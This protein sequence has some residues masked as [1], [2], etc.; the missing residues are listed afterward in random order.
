MPQWKKLPNGQWVVVPSVSTYFDRLNKGR[1]QSFNLPD[2]DSENFLLKQA[3]RLR[4]LTPGQR[5]FSAK[6]RKTI[7]GSIREALKAIPG[8]VADL[9]LS[10]AEATIG[11]LTPFAD[12][13]IEKRLRKISQDR[14][15]KR[16]PLYRD[17]L[18]VGV[19]QGLGQVTGLTA[20]TRIPGVGKALGFA[21][22]I[23]L[24]ISDQTRRIAEYEERTGENIPWYKET[25]AHL[26]GGAVGLSEIILPYKLAK[27]GSANRIQKMLSRTVPIDPGTTSGMIRSA[28]ESTATEGIQ[29]GLAQGLQ[30]MTAKGL[31]DP[32]AL[33]DLG[34]SMMEDLKVGGIVGGI[35]DV[36]A[37]ML[38]GPH[39]R[40]RGPQSTE[41]LQSERNEALLR[42]HRWQDEEWGS[43]TLDAINPGFVKDKLSGIMKEYNISRQVAEDINE[44]FNGEFAALPL[45]FETPLLESG[46]E[47]EQ[48][49]SIRDEL[50]T[51]TNSAI[52]V[53][54][55]VGSRA[56]ND[57]SRKDYIN[58][59]DAIRRIQGTRLSTLNTSI[60]KLG[61]GWRNLGGISDT[62]EYLRYWDS[63]GSDA[64]DNPDYDAL[65]A[66]L[67]KVV[68]GA[69]VKPDVVRNAIQGFLGGAYGRKGYKRLAELLG[70]HN[71]PGSEKVLSNIPVDGGLI[72]DPTKGSSDA[73]NFSTDDLGRILFGI[74]GNEG[75][76]KG[77]EYSDTTTLTGDVTKYN[78]KMKELEIELDEIEKDFPLFRVQA[79]QTEVQDDE[80]K[81]RPLLDKK[82]SQQEW[83][84]VRDN[85]SRVL[86]T[87]RGE[88]Y[89][90]MSKIREARGDR[91]TQA[92][93]ERL[94]YLQR[95]FSESGNREKKLQAIERLRFNEQYGKE[96]AEAAFDEWLQDQTVI[97]NDAK[98]RSDAHKAEMDKQVQQ[99]QQDLAGLDP[100]QLVEA[101][102]KMLPALRRSFKRNTKNIS[103]TNL[104]RLS[105]LFAPTSLEATDAV[106]VPM[107]IR[108]MTDIAQ[109]QVRH[110]RKA[111]ES[112]NL[113]IDETV[114][115]VEAFVKE[116]GTLKKRQNAQAKMAKR[117]MQMAGKDAEWKK[118][119]EKNGVMSVNEA[120]LRSKI[121]M[122]DAI[123]LAESLGYNLE[124]MTRLITSRDIEQLLGSKNIFL[125][126]TLAP[127][128]QGEEAVGYIGSR[129]EKKTGRGVDS[130]PF[131][132]LLADMTG[133]T[134]WNNA[135][136]A[137]RLL[138]YSRLLQLPSHR[139]KSSDTESKGLIFQPLY[140][141]DFY[142][143]EQS[144]KHLN[145]I[146][147]EIVGDRQGFQGK[148]DKIREHIKN[149]MGEE[150]D[151]Q[152]FDESIAS[153]IESGLLTH[154]SPTYQQESLVTGQSS[155]D[156]GSVID[157]DKGTPG[158]PRKRNIDKIQES[159][160]GTKDTA[161]DKPL[162]A[163]DT[164]E[165]KLQKIREGKQKALSLGSEDN[166]VNTGEVI[167]VSQNARVPVTVENIQEE[168]DKYAPERGLLIFGRGS[169]GTNEETIKELGVEAYGQYETGFLDDY[170]SLETEKFNPLTG[171]AGGV[172]IEDDVIGSVNMK[173]VEHAYNAQRIDS[174][175]DKGGVVWYNPNSATLKGE[176]D[177]KELI[178]DIIRVTP[179]NRI[180][181]EGNVT[182]LRNESI[183]AL[184]RAMTDAGWV[185]GEYHPDNALRRAMY[186]IAALADTPRAKGRIPV[187]TFINNPML[188][189]K[190][191]NLLGNKLKL[192]ETRVVKRYTPK[193]WKTV[194]IE[195]ETPLKEKDTKDPLIV[196]V[197][198]KKFKE[199]V[200]AK[201]KKKLKSRPIFTRVPEH[202]GLTAKGEERTSNV[203]Y[204]EVGP[205][206][207]SLEDSE[208][209]DYNKLLE[210]KF[211][212][213][214][215]LTKQLMYFP[216]KLEKKKKEDEGRGSG[217]I[218]ERIR[219]K[220]N[221]EMYPQKVKQAQ[222]SPEINSFIMTPRGLISRLHATPKEIK[223]ADNVGPVVIR[224]VGKPL[225]L[226]WEFNQDKIVIAQ[227]HAAE[228]EAIVEPFV[229]A[230]EIPMNF[231][232]GKMFGGVKHT[233][234][235]A[236][237]GKNTFQLI[238]E[239]KRTGTTR[240][241]PIPGVKAGDIIRIQDPKNPKKRG[242]YVQII[243]DWIKLGDSNLS[244][245][246]WMMSEGWNRNTYYRL[247]RKGGYHVRYKVLENAEQNTDAVTRRVASIMGLALP[248]HAK[249]E[250]IK[251]ASASL[252]VGQGA[253]DSSTAR[254]GNS[255]E[256]SD[257]IKYDIERD[258]YGVINKYIEFFADE[259][260]RNTAQV[261]FVAAN[262]KR[263]DRIPVVDKNGNLRG[264]YKSIQEMIEYSIKRG[265]AL[266]VFQLDTKEFTDKDYNIG[267]KEVAK[268]L[269]QAG[270]RR[271]PDQQDMKKMLDSPQD[272]WFEGRS[273]TWVPT[274]AVHFAMGTRLSA[275][276]F[277]TRVNGGERTAPIA[278]YDS[279]VDYGKLIEE[280]EKKSRIREEFRKTALFPYQED[281]ETSYV[282][283]QLKD[284]PFYLTPWYR[285]LNR[286]TNYD[287]SP[288]GILGELARIIERED[289]SIDGLAEF[290]EDMRQSTPDSIAWI[291]ILN[292][293]GR[294]RIPWSEDGTVI[295]DE[296]L[297]TVDEVD[298]DMLREYQNEVRKA[299]H[300][301]I[302]PGR[303][304]DFIITKEHFILRE[305]YKKLYEK[306]FPDIQIP[307]I[308]AEDKGR[309]KALAYNSIV[310][311]S[312]EGDVK[313]FIYINVD[314]VTKAF[315]DGL[316]K[317]T[318]PG[319]VTP[320]LVRKLDTK[321][322]DI[323][324][325]T[326]DGFIV[327][328]MAHE[329][330]HSKLRKGEVGF[331]TIHEESSR[332]AS[333]TYE[334]AINNLGLVEQSRIMY[335]QIRPLLIEQQKKR[336]EKSD[337]KFDEDTVRVDQDYFREEYADVR[338]E[339][340]DLMPGIDP[341]LE[342][343]NFI[344]APN[345]EEKMEIDREI[346][347]YH[348]K[349]QRVA[350]I[351]EDKELK[352]PVQKLTDNYNL[353]NPDDKLSVGEYIERYASHVVSRFGLAE[354]SQMGI[355]DT[356][357]QRVKKA[358][359]IVPG[360]TF[361]EINTPEGSKVIS[362]LIAQ[363]AIPSSLRKRSM[364]IRREFV[365]TIK[366]RF[367]VL[368][369]NIIEVLKVLR[370]P[371]NIKLQFVDDLNGLFQGL[372]EV[373]LRG[374]MLP[375]TQAAVYDSATNRIIINLAA[376]DPNDMVTAQEI[377]QEAG[378]HEAVH[379]LI[380]RDHLYDAELDELVKYIRNNVVSKEWDPDAHDM[381]VTWFERS[382][383]NNKDTDLN[384]SD[385]EEEAMT[386]LMVALAQN[387]VPDALIKNQKMRKTKG[388]L[389]DM[390]E[391]IV[392]AAKDSNIGEVLQVFSNIESGRTGSRGSGYQGDTE[393]TETDE[394]RNTRL[395]RYADPEQIKELTKALALLDAAKSP[396]MM[397]T[398]QANVDAI[399]DKIVQQRTEIRETAGE[400]D[401]L[402]AISNIREGVKEVQEENS[403]AIPLLNGEI[404]SNP[405]DREARQAALDEFLKSRRNEIGYTMPS[406][407]MSM[408]NRK[409]RVT[410]ST[411]SLIDS[412]VKEG[413]VND[414]DGDT[415]R[416]SL[417]SGTLA[418]DALVGDN[419]KETLD[420]LEK[421]T[422]SQ[423]RFQYL[424]RRQW[425]VEQT[426]RILAAQ[427][428]AMLDARTSA[429][430]M[431]RNADN[432][433]NWL[434]GM[435]KAGPLSYLGPSAGSGE[436]DIAP[437]YDDQLAEKYGGDG[438]VKGLLDIFAFV[439]Q[440]IDEQVATTYGEAKRIQWT[441][442]RRDEIRRMILP[443]T[444]WRD[445]PAH[446]RKEFQDSNLQEEL[447]IAEQA[448]NKINLD[449]NGKERWTDER[450]QQV[451]DKIEAD[452]PHIIEFWDNYQAY[453]RANIRLAYNTGL[454][455]REKRD[456][457]LDMPYAPFYRE[458]NE[459]DSFPIGSGQQMAMRGRVN[460]EKA[461]Q[462]SDAPVSKELME[463]IMINTQALVRDA[464]INVAAYRTARDSVSLREGRKV[465]VSEMAGNIDNR[466]IRVME[467]G[468]AQ[469]YELD[470]A[471][472]AMAV[473][474]L[475][476]NP[477][478]RIEDLFGGMKVG[479]YLSKGL[480]G[481]STLLREAV[482]RTPPFQVKNI[483]RDSWQASTLVG[484]G[485]SLVIDSIKNAMDPD[486]QRRAEER[487]ISIGIDFVA[488]PGEYG[489]LMKKE[490]EKSNLDWTNPLTPFSALWTFLGKIAK[491]SEVATRVAVY[492]RVLAMT[493]DRA[494]AQF[495]AVEI[496]NYGRRGA[497]PALSTYMATVPFMNGRLQGMD[498][499]YRGLRS[500]TGSSDVP[501]LTAYGMTQS[502]Y[503][504]LPWWEQ[505][506]AQIA[507]RGLVLTAA[508]MLMYWMMSDD[509]EYQDLRDEVK[510]DN[511]LFPLGDHAWLKIP[512]PFE[513]GVLFKVIPEQIMRAMME[514]Q[515]DVFDV[516]GEVKRQ[517]TTSLSI[518]APQM[519]APLFGAMQNYDRYR[520]DYIVDPF[521]ESSLSANEQR[522]RFT[523][524]TARTIADA[525]NMI[526]LVNNLDFLTSPMKMEYMLRQYFGTMGGYVTT[527]A[528]RVARMGI[529]PTVPF[530][531]L[532]NWSEAEGIVGT[533]VDFDWESL[534]GGPG[535][536]NVPILGDLLV[537]PRTRAGRQ[538]QF[539]EL[540]GELDT[541][542]GTLNSI[543]ERDW[544]DGFDYEEKHR[545]LLD[546]KSEIR[547]MERQMKRW[548]ERRDFE[549]DISEESL[550]DDQKRQRYQT[551]LNTRLDILDRM[552]ELLKGDKR[553]SKPFRLG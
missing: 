134:L 137:Q 5:G 472:Q 103:A 423:M 476:F 162:P 44:L 504:D 156:V 263:K 412:L 359:D 375:Q 351:L 294:K 238:Q 301:S 517:L 395:V 55:E 315:E 521:M 13:P 287:R 116:G 474:M 349:P 205:W 442:R 6:Q 230:M 52:G 488:E 266:P 445:R 454:I 475:G 439:S 300:G 94:V 314:N 254:Y 87:K 178:N 490:L 142:Q 231:T 73:S 135:S 455:T 332:T 505:N 520:K 450:M 421:G 485:P 17:S 224:V 352:Q 171:E 41:Q 268:W 64:Q 391:G 480:T 327:F 25:M 102:I 151:S 407:Y 76:I 525:V 316:Y 157:G 477:K 19:G 497:N 448:Y 97:V 354:L 397:A 257:S 370:I 91:Y 382:M 489:N 182:K 337:L 481:T 99:L 408:F 364:A 441:K 206:V 243:S 433:V 298:E 284:D 117:L 83:Q 468:V 45:G 344:V 222:V 173:S 204:E 302:A 92:L 260:N 456:L 464:M 237:R 80:G 535:V 299:L 493:G 105:N 429:T 424:D 250:G 387:K 74:E 379:A 190:V 217:P 444:R 192:V 126:G 51:R 405:R 271:I 496:M 255:P 447:K 113:V 225:P 138:M 469:H 46:V 495:L 309:P 61:G 550:T 165:T 197:G 518:G 409:H 365:N 133:A 355:L 262:G 7:P 513:I 373:S 404:W 544:K 259:K 233:M 471:Q 515:Y 459:T 310:E 191:S 292:T 9:G 543:T 129:L 422:V 367:E 341:D 311:Q 297:L 307:L 303:F 141:P 416:K 212:V 26:L 93:Y 531:P 98:N 215:G 186:N 499:V 38:L 463:N 267:E 90:S 155:D 330:A 109:W 216:Q 272:E 356:V 49:E 196:I 553:S 465:T 127:E 414:V 282:F 48:I 39:N 501:S 47:L 245:E 236:H 124:E 353:A 339:A 378:L 348:A 362:S 189:A 143:T 502:E 2:H 541:V 522:N 118:E 523:S 195:D 420:N 252:F 53:L 486:V 479:E 470:D 381:E 101:Q 512:I 159:G 510:A 529:L 498:V 60:E 453:N 334:D 213:N 547:Y 539:Y 180:N 546:K 218:L 478:K 428:R 106:N 280:A 136:E 158:N 403:Y 324:F 516:G 374:E 273:G 84:R 435:L 33:E 35:A 86:A 384:E 438:R 160:T 240:A 372:N 431:W 461:L 108:A 123:K 261:V 508:T 14:A 249:K 358:S 320:N 36:A 21:S 328:V 432:T 286:N 377:I 293:I 538:Q 436:F 59:A 239:G 449:E 511:W 131:K 70:V 57:E 122:K 167:E 107:I 291:K 494:L 462:G 20:L 140:L 288:R 318:Y 150:F 491:Q 34:A 410:S 170:H 386:D 411:K 325:A 244:P 443:R 15:A 88:I 89:E 406:R 207:E 227:A 317:A 258:R 62:E 96:N 214:S 175:K 366:T 199:R 331:K 146:V 95:Y 322:E 110:S 169:I 390:F 149:K 220:R 524:N 551:L 277:E 306:I 115:V 270:Y 533:S 399:A 466:V 537:D 247:L 100:S 304:K 172:P 336:R 514:E 201:Q 256:Y 241:K 319:E 29:E 210:L 183:V 398:Q 18:A 209:P 278:L 139:I 132:K 164:G 545:E 368:Q 380:R 43:E 519:I 104:V 369:D 281:T 81:G 145:Y 534:I 82:A 3:E 388:L 179:K 184:E 23:A 228:A 8:G 305:K 506:R 542:V 166:N 552:D 11:L 526:P 181:S 346:F 112:G 549:F 376:I 383:Y 188:A 153:L 340:M 326:V 65:E 69:K 536:A 540:V 235:E 24:G 500:K 507:N 202:I 417:E 276:G 253:P 509:E 208:G 308:I 527:V 323:R 211:A 345:S 54:Q 430:V 329:K 30:S 482:T 161:S 144:Q 198:N 371:D 121:N 275:E 234:Q 219:L 361:L 548:R 56:P 426:D 335:D 152:I 71:G 457:W 187:A 4:Q 401:Q 120:L 350:E 338:R 434:G 283:D 394:I 128:N 154:Y 279:M 37:N 163:G 85:N 16:D 492:D 31:Y 246:S 72:P 119:T 528:D 419:P 12:L 63:F 200:V 28:L 203:Y 451:I 389:S 385:I 78:R 1:D 194:Y 342:R 130:T 168:L 460:V 400:V 393:F 75:K 114:G 232:D 425:T 440:P 357:Q 125:R 484:G 50:A 392:G 285:N 296:D 223:D 32:N 343:K 312:P 58:A 269:T 487:G 347:E 458:T 27:I 68:K 79:E 147:E 290:V 176:T 446:F 363:G 185:R 42:K 226:S 413:A 483:F 321:D 313:N 248:K 427:D 77:L 67:G 503:A 396:E 274:G 452:E 467:Q 177:S 10:G 333:L 265:L 289:L 532:M 251:A 530:D 242:I 473:M 66:H 418:G 360:S 111:V 221:Q 415:F 174:K 40:N 402:Q 22:S 437:V 193:V 148:I 264:K 229:G 295:P